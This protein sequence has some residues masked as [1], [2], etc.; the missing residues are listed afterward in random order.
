MTD[1]QI[2][3]EQKS[4]GNALK[5]TK[6][7]LQGMAKAAKATDKSLDALGMS[8]KDIDKSF[9]RANEEIEAMRRG[10]KTTTESLDGYNRMMKRVSDNKMAK[11]LDKSNKEIK[12]MRQGTKD[13]ANT[14]AQW[15]AAMKRAGDKAREAAA[16]T[17]KLKRE[18]QQ[19]SQKAMAAERNT[20][21]FTRGL[22][23]LATEAKE[24]GRGIDK[25]GK[26]VDQTEKKIS[27]ARRA[28]NKL[29]NAL[30]EGL[31]DG[32][33]EAV[34]AAGD[35]IKEADKA[36]KGFNKGMLEV[37][38]L[39]PE[40]SQETFGRMQMDVLALGTEIGR[41]PEETIPALY[42]ALSLG[43][44]E[45]N[46]LAQVELA[47]AAAK[48]GVA[49]LET[50]M[51][52]GQSVVNA[53][54]GELISL[55]EVYDIMFTA[56][57]NGA[58]TFN[59]MNAT[60]SNVTSIAGESRVSFQDVAAALVVMTRQGD[61]AAEATELLGL[62]LGQLG[63]DGTA[64]A[65]AF[66]ESAGQSFRSYI[67]E[68]GNLAGALKLMEDQAD[69]TGVT[70]GA[71]IGGSSPFYRD[72]QAARAALELTGVNMEVLE[73][74]TIETNNAFGSMGEASEV[75]G[76]AAVL[77]SDIAAAAWAEFKIEFG[78]A[79]SGISTEAAKGAT[80]F[81]KMFSGNY[82][83][84]I[85]GQTEAIIEQALSIEE[86]IAVGQKLTEQEGN[87]GSGLLGVD[88]EITDGIEKVL[89][90]IAAETDS[91]EEFQAAAAEATTVM[92]DFDNE[93]TDVI[94]PLGVS[95]EEFYNSAKAASRAAYE[96]ELWNAALDQGVKGYIYAGEMAEG[97]SDRV[98]DLAVRTGEAEQLQEQMAR[99]QG[100]LALEMPI[101][102]EVV[103]E[104]AEAVDEL[105]AAFSEALAQQE[106]LI[107]STARYFDMALNATGAL[108]TMEMAL[109]N[110]AVA[111]NAPIEV[112]EVLAANLDGVDAEMIA[113]AVAFDK[114][115]KAAD[116]AALA[117]STYSLTA[118]ET[119]KAQQLFQDGLVNSTAGAAQ[120]IGQMGLADESL[121]TT[122]ENF[123]DAKL[124]VDELTGAIGTIPPVVE[125]EVIIDETDAVRRIQALK[126]EI[127]SMIAK[128]G[129]AELGLPAGAGSTGSG[130]NNGA[131][132]TPGDGPSNPGGNQNPDTFAS[133]GYIRGGIPGRDSVPLLATPGEFVIR[134]KAARQLGPQILG[135]INRSGAIPATSSFNSVSS[136]AGGPSPAGAGNGQN[137]NVFNDNA[138]YVVVV[139]NNDRAAIVA[140]MIDE[141]RQA[142][143]NEFWSM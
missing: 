119:A 31:A 133:G 70:L 139:D 42:Q 34:F 85:E 44:D 25:L 8:A 14:T 50:T 47:A 71:M 59:D 113:T 51:T 102:T 107:T 73:E 62:L 109:Y 96:Q 127:D 20:K 36:F 106:A 17:D 39:A 37:K 118:E 103:E 116:M 32:F 18:V 138:R 55:E 6:E 40:M 83:R 135:Q 69:R 110:A 140:A 111:A 125:T 84:Q 82:G 76:D 105:T 57:K 115:Q 43:I 2:V 129:A 72:T 80:V 68:G 81:A 132:S 26:E 9:D 58:L 27:A 23:N 90:L 124:G 78:R 134:E 60:L 22:S 108:E 74:Q 86:L 130:N 67:E 91:L 123:L 46:A 99:T 63:T 131:P 66:S 30:K 121:A 5:E 24:A 15:G 120:W 49:E 11:S 136:G 33:S 97:Y 4:K 112:L 1:V 56:V 53:Y 126:Y 114:Q 13:A 64:A 95:T 3:I 19:A 79:I 101:V 98:Y 65:A 28:A 87:L 143:L 10:S 122:R 7:E 29:G 142:A 12:E 38:T 117:M 52:T 92:K 128:L 88:D 77:Q 35:F 93:L 45:D 54:G 137:G 16:A 41:L 141:R 61:S 21:K 89:T 104:E 75:M 100:Q 94:E 48:A